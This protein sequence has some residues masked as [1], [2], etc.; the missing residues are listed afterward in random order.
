MLG[1]GI[2]DRSCRMKKQKRKG[3]EAGGFGDH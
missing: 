2:L 1:L 3:A